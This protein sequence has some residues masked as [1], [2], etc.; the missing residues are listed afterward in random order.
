MT[1]DTSQ[2]LHPI[3]RKGYAFFHSFTMTLITCYSEMRPF[4]D[5]PGRIVIKFARLPMFRAMTTSAIG[6]SVYL[7]LISVHIFM[8]S[9]T[10]C[11]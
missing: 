4:Q 10:F 11:G 5:K 2:F 6:N 7:K 9:F 1:I 8:T 3:K